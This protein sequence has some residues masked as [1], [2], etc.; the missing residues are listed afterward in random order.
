[1][2]RGNILWFLLI[3]FL[4]GCKRESSSDK[5]NKVLVIKEMSDLATTEYIV[6]K[7]IKANDNK[8]WFKVGDRKILM[9]CKAHITAGIDL[10]SI[11]NENVKVD[12][13]NIF[14]ELPH[15]KL[16]SLNIKPEDI[17]TEYEDISEFRSGFSAAEKNALAIQGETNI[18]NSVD[19]L[20]VIQTAEVNATLF[21]SGFLEKLGYTNIHI[22]YGN[23][24]PSYLK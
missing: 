14:L 23:N 10:S 8:T 24:Q 15:A 17:K 5:I 7:I 2:K 21:L 22:T 6:T 18:R 4:P 1:M 12:N 3:I 19:S 9:S 13:K 20:G 11:K 16:L